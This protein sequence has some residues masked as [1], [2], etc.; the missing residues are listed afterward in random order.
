MSV[1]NWA[2]WDRW[3]SRVSVIC[4]QSTWVSESN[5][6]LYVRKKIRALVRSWSTGSALKHGSI[7]ALSSPYRQRDEKVFSKYPLLTI[8]IHQLS[9]RFNQCFFIS[10][11]YK[12]CTV[13]T[14]FNQSCLIFC[15]LCEIRS[16]AHKQP[17]ETKPTPL[18]TWAQTTN[19]GTHLCCKGW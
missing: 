19:P 15:Y 8:H 13:R 7:H 17:W 12:L 3:S 5:L 2:G 6:F 9:F 1:E 18:C 16:S 14:V 4:L 10:I 11:M